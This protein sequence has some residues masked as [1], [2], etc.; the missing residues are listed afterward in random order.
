[1][2]FPS[3]SSMAANSVERQRPVGDGVKLFIAVHEL[4]HAC[5]LGQGDH[6]PD[7][8][9]D[10]FI[11]QPQPSPGNTPS[12]DKLRIRLQPF[13]ALPDDPPAQPLFLTQR[14]ADMIRS[15]WN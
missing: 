5:G 9:P 6:S 4:I 15:I 11:P 3:A 10:F 14:T 1:M 7:S 12:K 13:R 8:S 2:I